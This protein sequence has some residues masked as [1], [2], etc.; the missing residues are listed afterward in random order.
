MR[1]KFV[2]TISLENTETNEVSPSL[3]VRRDT[4]AQA[5]EY[6]N[7]AIAA[8]NRPEL[9]VHSMTSRPA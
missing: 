6:A 1:G 9:R 4:E 8:C 2:F 7:A 3:I 5:R